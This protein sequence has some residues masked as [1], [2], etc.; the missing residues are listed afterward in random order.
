MSGII[1]NH[2]VLGQQERKLDRRDVLQCV[3]LQS[4]WRLE[5]GALRVDVVGADGNYGF[6][7]LVLPG[8]VVGIENLVA[9]TD[10]RLVRALT[11][12]YLRQVHLSDEGQIKDMLVDAYSRIY[13]RTRELIQLRTGSTDARVKRLLIALSGESL[14]GHTETA[15][16][17]L[18]S[19]SDIAAIVDAAPESVCR[20]LANLRQNNFLQDLS[21]T[22]SKFK[23]LG[24]RPTLLHLGA[25]L[26]PS[27]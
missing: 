24:N 23:H 10:Q 21:A 5:S 14:G 15:Q 27:V 9:I 8:D 13:Q 6:D 22:T 18:P 26:S 25:S 4:L 16:C 17:A 20:S 3:D 2:Y 1:M 19:L 7:R 12:S 11:P